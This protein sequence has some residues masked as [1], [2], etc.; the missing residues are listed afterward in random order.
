VNPRVFGPGLENG[1]LPTFVSA[2]LCDVSKVKLGRGEGGG[3]GGSVLQVAIK[4][5]KGRLNG[6]FKSDDDNGLIIERGD[7]RRLY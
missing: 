4:G 5:P 3:G 7:Q 6:K 1:V 2:F